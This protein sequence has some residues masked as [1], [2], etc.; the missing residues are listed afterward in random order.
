M[1]KERDAAMAADTGQVP[2]VLRNV[3]KMRTHE[4]ALAFHLTG[5]SNNH[6]SLLYTSTLL[7]VQQMHRPTSLAFKF[8]Q[9]S[10]ESKNIVSLEYR[11]TTVFTWIIYPVFCQAAGHS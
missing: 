2:I 6:T 3:S 1:T 10:L 4:D 9:H 7:P 11:S 5:P 8:M